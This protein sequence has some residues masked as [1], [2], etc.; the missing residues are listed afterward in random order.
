MGEEGH[1]VFITSLVI[2]VISHIWQNS[3]IRE[4]SSELI[5]ASQSTGIQQLLVA[6]KKS[7]EK[8]AE[9]RKRK[10]PTAPL[11]RIIIDLNYG[12]K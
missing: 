1:T 11:L 10:Y 3:A 5:M 2:T 12:K 7:A 6:E 9:A 8:V 4:G